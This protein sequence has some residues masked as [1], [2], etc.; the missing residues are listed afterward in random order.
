MKEPK[1]IAFIKGINESLP[2]LIYGIIGFGIIC[3]I[4]GLIVV[5]NLLNYSI[6][7]W[8][9]VLIAIAM[10]FHMALTLNRAVEKNAKDAQGYATVQNLLRYFI[11]VIILGILMLT[12]IGNPLACFAGIMG[13]KVSAYLQPVWKKILQ[14][15]SFKRKNKNS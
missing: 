15:I 12:N 8:M 3:Q 1:L 9:G 14:K 10:S 2:D 4:F 6:G 5:D 11:V 7:L 13:I